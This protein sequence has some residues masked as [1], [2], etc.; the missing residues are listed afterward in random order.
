MKNPFYFTLKA[1]FVLKRFQ[2]LSRHFGHVE[3]LLDK[4]KKVKFKV[5][6]F[7]P[8]LAGNCYSL[9]TQYFKK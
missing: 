4:K 9:I 6:D 2:F 3:K 7:T 1:L 8:W 5:F